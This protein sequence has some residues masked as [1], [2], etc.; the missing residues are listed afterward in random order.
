MFISRLK[1]S[2]IQFQESLTPLFG[3]NYEI[4]RRIKSSCPSRSPPTLSFHW[5]L[6]THLP[7][8]QEPISANFA[9]CWLEIW[10]KPANIFWN[11]PLPC[12]SSFQNS[13]TSSSPILL[14]KQFSNQLPAVV[15]TQDLILWI[16]GFN[17]Y[18]QTTKRV[19]WIIFFYIYCS[20]GFHFNNTFNSLSCAKI[21]IS[22][23][24][25][26]Q[27]KFIVKA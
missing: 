10:N 12:Q 22:H 6:Q 21:V 19:L 11:F 3:I 8:T 2:L 23:W 7:F 24:M 4:S 5:K 25:I 27:K 20:S 16:W 9:S 14:H 15:P 17:F 13:V 18:A 26:L 1:P